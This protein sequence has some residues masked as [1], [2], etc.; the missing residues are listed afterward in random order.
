LIYLDIFGCFSQ[1]S[2]LSS[3]LLANTK[4]KPHLPLL[5]LLPPLLPLSRFLLLPLHLLPYQNLLTLMLKIT[6]T[7]S[8]ARKRSYP[9][10]KLFSLT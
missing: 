9:V 10:E 8:I 5:L 1:I 3:C 2:S 4:G 7:T 6:S